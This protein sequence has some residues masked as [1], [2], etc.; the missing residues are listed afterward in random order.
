[1]LKYQEQKLKKS[2]LDKIT[3]LL[4]WANCN[5]LEFEYQTVQVCL[6]IK[7]L[8]FIIFKLSPQCL[9]F[10]KNLLQIAKN[11]IQRSFGQLKSLRQKI[12]L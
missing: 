9:V 1:M 6:W 3:Y 5:A 11:L 10:L 4:L 7:V 12:L 2:Q 8:F